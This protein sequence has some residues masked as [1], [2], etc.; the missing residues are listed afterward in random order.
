MHRQFKKKMTLLEAATTQTQQ[1]N[2]SQKTKGRPSNTTYFSL[3]AT[4]YHQT[5]LK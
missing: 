5:L 4:E 1:T 3:T 2:Q